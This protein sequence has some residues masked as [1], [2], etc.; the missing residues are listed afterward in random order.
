MYI[1]S[2][3]KQPL[4]N[5]V[6]LPL[7]PPILKPSTKPPLSL[8]AP[9]PT[10]RTNFSP[11][12]PAP[13]FGS[14][15]PITGY[16][17]S[18][19]TEPQRP[20]SH[21][22][23]ASLTLAGSSPP[24]PHRLKQ[25]SPSQPHLPSY[26]S[27]GQTQQPP[28]IPLRISSIPSNN[29][30]RKLSLNKHPSL[31]TLRPARKSTEEKETTFVDPQA[32]GSST[33]RKVSPPLRTYKALPNPPMNPEEEMQTRDKVMSSSPQNWSTYVTA[34]YSP[35]SRTS[36][37]YKRGG[38]IWPDPGRDEELSHPG[39]AELPN[40]PARTT[41]SHARLHSAPVTASLYQPFQSPDVQALATAASRRSPPNTF[42]SEIQPTAPL[43][44]SPHSKQKSVT[45]TPASHSVTQDTHTSQT[46]KPPKGKEKQNVTEKGG[47]AAG[48]QTG[49]GRPVQQSRT[50]KDKDR[51]KRSKAKILIE[52][53]DI[54]RDEFWDKRPWILSGKTG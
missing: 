15:F 22:A 12:S 14:T 51:K 32:A 6:P 10:T 23:S 36:D 1:T 24:Q 17:H 2:G 28:A 43:K 21:S 11:T 25:R 16:S 26:F 7:S 33:P 54:I 45:K 29:K 49:Q 53:V 50:Q 46:A 41:K 38:Q 18:T 3:P 44:D 47:W 5:L 40:T 39:M 35:P 30:P 48:T 20:M 13:G 52:H 27:P 31:S 37:H 9:N 19:P 42:E 4:P 8:N 34:R